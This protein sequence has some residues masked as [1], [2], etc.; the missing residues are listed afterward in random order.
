[1]KHTLAQRACP[2]DSTQQNIH[3]QIHIMKHT[4]TQTSHAHL[5]T[6]QNIEAHAHVIKRTIIATMLSGSLNYQKGLTVTTFLIRE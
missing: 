4:L 3:T 1:M 2:T 5:N 6:N